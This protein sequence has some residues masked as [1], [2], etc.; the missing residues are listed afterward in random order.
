M[1]RKRGWKIVCDLMV[2]CGDMKMASFLI[3]TLCLW[4]MDEWI[5]EREIWCGE[6]RKEGKI[7][8]SCSVYDRWMLMDESKEGHNKPESLTDVFQF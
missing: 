4:R 6:G 3:I 5:V 8:F 7:P 1:K 2:G